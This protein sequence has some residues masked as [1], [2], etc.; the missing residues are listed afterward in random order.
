MAATNA[1]N[2][3]KKDLEGNTA[4]YTAIK[5]ETESGAYSYPNG[6][7]FWDFEAQII[8]TWHE[9]EGKWY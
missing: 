6:S 1:N 2:P 3:S 5:T 7:T 4:E 9:A 8:H